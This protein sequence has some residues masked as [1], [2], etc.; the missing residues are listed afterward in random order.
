MAHGVYQD[1]LCC[2]CKTKVELLK[3]AALVAKCLHE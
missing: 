3:F 2:F 1:L